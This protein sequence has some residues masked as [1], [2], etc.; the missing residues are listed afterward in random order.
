MFEACKLCL[1]CEQVEVSLPFINDRQALEYGRKGSL[2]DWN[3]QK[4]RGVN[5]G[6]NHDIKE[7][8][9]WNLDCDNNWLHSAIMA[10][11]LNCF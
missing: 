9:V 8:A 5:G 6:K 11:F 3:E 7:V 10:H 1:G 2:I 4:K